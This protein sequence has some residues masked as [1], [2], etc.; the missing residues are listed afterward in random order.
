[1]TAAGGAGPSP[2]VRG[3]LITLLG[4][5]VLS[6]DAALVR[7]VDTSAATMI[8]WRGVGVGLVT[9]GL[10]VAVGGRRAIADFVA[11]GWL[12]ALL[13]LCMATS[14][15]AWVAGVTF[16]N[17]SHVLVL[18]ATA[19][20]FGALA[21]RVVL[22]ERVRPATVA[23]MAAGLVAVAI[24]AS[25]GLKGG[26]GN[27]AGD[28]AGLLVAVVLGVGFTLIRKLGLANAWMHFGAAALL[29]AAWIGLVLPLEPVEGTRLALLA[30]LVLVVLPAA[31]MLIT[32][33]PRYI[34]APEVSLMMLLEAPFGAAFLWLLASEPPTVEAV[35]GG[36]ILIGALA[37]HA[38]WLAR[39]PAPRAPPAGAGAGGG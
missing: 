13:V 3:T 10:G 30:L 27:P 33:G 36:T 4:V 28:L 31:F 24:I 38:L 29:N 22:K 18:V 25:S 21:S 9:I 1:M 32:V 39:H 23:A 5:L 7:M 12:G 2:Q 6:P 14:Q 37:A 17:P 26:G 35:V 8:F 20:L 34:T 19:P 16:T 15:V 11:T